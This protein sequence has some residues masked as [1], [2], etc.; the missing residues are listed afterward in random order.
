MQAHAPGPTREGLRRVP[1]GLIAEVA[2]WRMSVPFNSDNEAG[3]V[4]LGGV[5]RFTK[6]FL[7]TFTA[8]NG[9]AAFEEAKA[10]VG[11]LPGCG[12]GG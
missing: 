3:D 5:W 1:E 6:E 11:E 12:L 8:E 9:V 4:G 7:E 2:R 10:N